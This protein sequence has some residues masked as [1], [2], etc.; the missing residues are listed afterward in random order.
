MLAQL[1][2]P[3]AEAN[4]VGSVRRSAVKLAQRLRFSEA[5]Q[6]DVAIVAT[7]LATNLSRHAQNGRVWLQTISS[8]AGE[9]L[10]LVAVDA[11]PGIPDLQ[12]CLR[13]G[14][15]SAGTAG[16]GFGAIRRLSHEFDVFTTVGRGTVVLS[17]IYADGSRGRAA[18]VIGAM[19]QPAPHEVVCGDAW[20]IIER[21]GSLAVIVA[22]GLGH[23]PLAAEASALAVGAFEALPFADAAAFYARANDTLSSSRG[24]AVARALVDE[25]GK[26][27]YSGVGNIAGSLLGPDGSRGL[28]SQNGTV[29]SPMRRQVAAQL[30]DWPTRG[31]LVM[32][33]DGIM[34]RW[35]FDP[36][37][38]LLVRHPAVIAA[39]LC[40]D[41]MRGRD[42]ATVVVVGRAREDA[43]S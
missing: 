11:G 13:D 43:A 17:R 19:S 18:F 10:E 37:P 27:E 7:E 30:Y 24:A 42:D 16:T 12:R 25:S 20:R 38:G 28:P 40:R 34:S 33:S 14:Y 31:V 8:S 9:G 2:I 32:H 5:Q 36:Y 26:V 15:S 4:H 1:S 39:I 6:S 41:F 29:G 22:D 21:G 23:G 35:S 3:A